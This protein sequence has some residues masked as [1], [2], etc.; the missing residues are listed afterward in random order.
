P[1][2]PRWSRPSSSRP[3]RAATWRPGW[4]P[5]A[6]SSP[7]SSTAPGGWAPGCSTASA[8]A[9]SASQAAVPAAAAP[10]IA[11][12]AR[13]FRGYAAP[14]Q[15]PPR[16]RDAMRPQQAPE[17]AVLLGQGIA[18]ALGP[19]EAGLRP[20]Q[21]AAQQHEILVAGIHSLLPRRPSLTGHPTPPE[22]ILIRP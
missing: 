14:G 18:L 9:A 6:S 10:S 8:D 1:S 22:G 13:L 2:C 19:A 16:Q 12:L 4:P 3:S 20:R 11:Y 15:E 5:T 17:L 7:S 21:L